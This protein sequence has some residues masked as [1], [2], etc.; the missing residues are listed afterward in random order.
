MSEQ[1]VTMHVASASVGWILAQMHS[2]PSANPGY[3]ATLSLCACVRKFVLCC[4][5][6]AGAEMIPD[7]TVWDGMGAGLQDMGDMG[8]PGIGRQ[9]SAS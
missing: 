4:D 6:T 8:G 1:H 9:M 2:P 5:A 3:P 7:A